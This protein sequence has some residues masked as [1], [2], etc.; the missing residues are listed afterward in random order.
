[1]DETALRKPGDHLVRVVRRFET[2]GVGGEW[3]AITDAID[4]GAER[5]DDA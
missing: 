2:C 1:L 3:N 4:S 5:N